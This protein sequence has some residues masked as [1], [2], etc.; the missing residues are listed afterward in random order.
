MAGN[1]KKIDKREEWDKFIKAQKSAP[2]LQSWEWGEFQESLDRKVLR[3][4]WDEKIFVQ[5]IKMNLP[6]GFAYWYIPRGPIA[7]D[8]LVDVND[9]MREL[10]NDLEKSGALFLRIDPLASK[11]PLNLPLGKGERFVAS[12]QPQCTRILDLTK[13]EESLL[14][15]MHQKTRYNIRLAERKGVKIRKGAITEFIR[16][17]HE[18]KTR[19]KFTTHTDEHYQKMVKTLPSEFIKIWH[20][21]YKGKVL[22]SAIII[23]FSDTATYAHGAS[24]D[25]HRDLMAPHL[26]QWKII[27]DA[28]SKGFKNYDFFGVNPDTENHKA[29]KKSW[30]G[31]TRFKAGFGGDLICYPHSF[32]LIYR[33]LWYR[34]YKLV[35]KLKTMI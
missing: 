4:S 15:G 33:A 23:Y 27:Q 21:E 8:K 24:S 6:K 10:L 5:A 17:N 7:L 11:P 14:S 29:Y 35:K 34:V 26:L 25:E 1:W 30:Q 9:A 32:D 31:I 19:D 22:A 12:T 2:F 16:L 3:F 18:T 20:A 28:K 13:H